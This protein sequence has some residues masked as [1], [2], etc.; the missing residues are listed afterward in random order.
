M[1]R[2]L[3][4]IYNRLFDYIQQDESQHC[5]LLWGLGH[6]YY[7][8]PSS[9]TSAATVINGPLLEV[10]MEMELGKKDGAIYLR[11]KQ[12][13]HASSASNGGGGVRINREVLT[14]LLRHSNA[15]LSKQQ[16]NPNNSNSGGTTDTLLQSWYRKVQND[17]D[18][19]QISPAQ[20]ETYRPILQQ[21]A[22]ELLSNGV[23]IDSTT[24]TTVSSDV[25]HRHDPQKTCIISD[26][27]CLYVS[28]KPSSIL[29]RDALAFVDRIS[30]KNTIRAADVPKIAILTNHD[31]RIRQESQTEFLPAA[32]WAITHGP[33]SYE[34]YRK[35]V[36]EIESLR[37]RQGNGFLQWI[38]SSLFPHTISSNM[39]S[40]PTNLPPKISLPLPSTDAQ[41]RIV[42]ML[43]YQNY[44][45]VV[46]E[47]PPGTGKSQTICNMICAYLRVGKR[48]L[49]TSK[50]AS[51]LSVIRKRLPKTIQELCIDVSNSEYNGVRQLQQTVERLSNRLANSTYQQQVQQQLSGSGGTQLST[52]VGTYVDSEHEKLLHIQKLIEEHEQE[53]AKIDDT[54]T[55]HYKQMYQLLQSTDGKQYMNIAIELL[56]T[57]PWLMSTI[58]TWTPYAVMKLRDQIEAFVL[59]QSNDPIERVCS[60]P[61]PPSNALISL[62]ASN[63]D[64]KIHVASNVTKKAVASIPFVGSWIGMDQH[65]ANLDREISM[66]RIGD[67]VPTS[68]SDWSIVVRALRR[69]QAMHSY[70]QGTWKTY[71]HTDS[72]PKAIDFFANHDNIRDLYTNLCKAVEMKNLGWKLNIY[73]RIAASANCQSLDSKRCTLS[74]Q[75]HALSE[76]LV[77]L[78][79]VTELC[80]SLSEEALSAL[81]RFSQIAGKAKFHKPN[82]PVA[83][84]SQRQRRHRDDYLDAFDQCCRY[85]PCW[86]LTTSQISD[87]LPPEPLFDLVIIDETSQSDI[88]VLPTMLRGKQWLIVGDGKQVSPTETFISEEQMEHLRAI[89]PQ[90]YFESALLPGQSFFDLCAQAFPTSRV[91]ID[92]RI[93][94]FIAILIGAYRIATYF[95]IHGSL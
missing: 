86:I 60:Y 19:A 87:F 71:E 20:P 73:D 95:L 34:R 42:D 80:R 49:V 55:D 84:M 93:V 9:T 52:N 32:T 26:T 5:E 10:P 58:A 4:P 35:Q 38:R 17:I 57:M 27:W 45:C 14:A 77:N 12:S 94:S 81:I 85:I 88:T 54:I 63:A 56:Q 41:H 79:V 2:I 28:N 64:M 47:G 82:I 89:I 3:E 70:G 31:S 33:G 7:I 1:K 40:I 15:A 37:R 18:I 8:I 68:P 51:S 46:V 43:L 13:P 25:H 11:P 6:A 50:N 21:M 39:K 92:L 44:P 67:H 91:S 74:K 62:A 48:I 66:I 36:D 16:G 59:Q 65:N 30:K 22:M 83:K 69:A 53:V 90:C 24:A 72:W 61:N 23:F 75:I 29:S 76:E 78:T